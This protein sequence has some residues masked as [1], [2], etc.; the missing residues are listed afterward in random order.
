MNAGTLIATILRHDHKVTSYKISLIR[1]INDVVLGFPHISQGSASI[2]LP[3]RTL[4][5]FWVAYYWPFVNP[6]Q[7]ILQG[8]Q[9]SG[10]ED[11]SF[12]PALTH[13]RREWEKLVGVSRPS[14]GHFL[15]GEFLSEI[16]MNAYPKSLSKSFSEVI[17]AITTAIQQPIRYASP[18]Q[19]NVFAPPRR[20]KDILSSMP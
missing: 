20:W 10:K 18:D 6:E 4:A 1:S 2:A 17:R 15:V 14:D 16:R 5:R 8:Q 9:T 12:R 3:L 11:I 7:A 13:L 19:Y